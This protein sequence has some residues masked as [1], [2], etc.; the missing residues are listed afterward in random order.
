MTFSLIIINYRTYQ[1]TRDCLN[2]LLKYCAP[3]QFE[4]IL[5]DNN[6][7]DESI[8][9]L[10]TEFG[11]QIKIIKN[12]ANLGFGRANNQG[13]K[14]A[15]GDWLFF[16]NSDTVVEDDILITLKK[17]ISNHPQAGII[18][19]QLLNSQKQPQ[20]AAFGSKPR[21]SDLIRKNFTTKKKINNEPI[22][23]VSGAALLISQKIFTQ[24]NGWDE[25][26]FMYLEDT[27]LCLRVKKIGYQINLCQDAK[28]IHLGG[29]SFANNKIKKKY[30]FKS[31]N[32]FFRQ[33]YGRMTEILMRIIR[34][35]YKLWVLK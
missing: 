15:T 4:I 12:Q 32:Y 14:I 27:D 13:A 18:A 25:N 3:E 9:K 26:F 16:L 11:D 7:H 20:P 28:V 21:L 8:E 17:F 6:S 2:S 1:L 5:V 19:P 23:W 30:Y 29:G 22:D 35:P 34:L 10:E 24:V 31:Q 33:H